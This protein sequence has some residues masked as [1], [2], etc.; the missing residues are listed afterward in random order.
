MKMTSFRDMCFPQHKMKL[1][2]KLIWI[3]QITQLAVMALDF[4]YEKRLA[5]NDRRA[6]TL[7]VLGELKD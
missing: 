3:R 1:I 5:I 4:S 7:T 2:S 6:S